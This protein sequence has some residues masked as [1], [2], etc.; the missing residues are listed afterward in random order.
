MIFYPKMMISNYNFSI[1]N[2]NFFI[3][4]IFV[5]VLYGIFDTTIMSIFNNC[6]WRI[7][8]IDTL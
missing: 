8:L 4:I 1:Y 3:S 5:I 2:I 6:N 7:A